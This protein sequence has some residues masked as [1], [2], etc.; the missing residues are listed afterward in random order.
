MSISHISPHGE[1]A[2]PHNG[3]LD[4]TCGQ[5]ETDREGTKPTLSADEEILQIDRGTLTNQSS[6]DYYPGPFSTMSVYLTL[7]LRD[8]LGKAE[9]PHERCAT[10]GTLVQ[11]GSGSAF[12]DV[13]LSIL[14]P[15]PNSWKPSSNNGKATYRADWLTTI[16]SLRISWEYRSKRTLCLLLIRYLAEWRP[17]WQIQK[18]IGYNL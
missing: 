15:R 12:R 3:R 6:I 2:L 14:E 17:M 9:V 4:Q 8:A 10:R 7:D 1:Y 11:T 18:R 13:P 16:I 5:L